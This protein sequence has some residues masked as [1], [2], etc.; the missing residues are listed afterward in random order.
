MR[1]RSDTGPDIRPTNCVTV[2]DTHDGIGVVDVAP[3]GDK[4]DFEPAQVDALVEAMHD[5]RGPQPRVHRAAASNL[6]L[7]QVNGTYSRRSAATMP[8]RSSVA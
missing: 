7:Y 2:L 3:E 1:S 5:A 6:D 4:P 8:P